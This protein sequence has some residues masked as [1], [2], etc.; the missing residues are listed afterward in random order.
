MSDENADL[1]VQEKSAKQLS[2]ENADA[3]TR[4][5]SKAAV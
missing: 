3:G 4:K 2:D 5:V 1:Q